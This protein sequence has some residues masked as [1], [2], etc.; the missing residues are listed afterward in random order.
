MQENVSVSTKSEKMKLE[1]ELPKDF[2][3]YLDAFAG[4]LGFCL[5][6]LL[7]R[8]LLAGLECEI[9][10]IEGWDFPNAQYYA[11][12]G[13]EWIKVLSKASSENKEDSE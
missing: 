4:W 2:A 5:D 10:A 13:L 1:I 12:Q 9:R 3:N 11:E 8:V 7:M 6:E